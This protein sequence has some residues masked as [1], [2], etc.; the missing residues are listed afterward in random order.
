MT[1]MA[2][3]KKQ[4]PDFNPDVGQPA[5]LTAQ[6]KPQQGKT[7]IGGSDLV[8]DLEAAQDADWAWHA[9]TSIGSA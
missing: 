6:E 7:H 2:A 1:R 5:T 9:A 4:F 3:R 8:P